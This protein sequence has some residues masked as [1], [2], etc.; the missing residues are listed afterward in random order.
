VV[1]G[2]SWLFKLSMTGGVKCFLKV[3]Y[4]SHDWWLLAGYYIVLVPMTGCPKLI[5]FSY[6]F[7]MYMREPFICLNI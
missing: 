6:L 5:N 4:P 2:A 7:I 1:V 3:G